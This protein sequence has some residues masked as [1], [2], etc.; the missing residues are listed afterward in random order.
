MDFAIWDDFKLHLP[1]GVGVADV[2]E[3]I[4]IERRFDRST[5]ADEGF[6]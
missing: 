1:V 5:D 4:E 6:L 3:A 2:V